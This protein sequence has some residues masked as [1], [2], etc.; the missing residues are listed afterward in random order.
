MS[1]KEKAKFVKEAAMSKKEKAKFVV[2]RCYGA[3]VHVGTLV[4]QDAKLVV[5]Q[6]ARR[7]WRWQGANTLNEV[8]LRGVAQE[9]TRLSEPVSEVTLSDVIEVLA[10]TADAE[11]NLSVSRWAK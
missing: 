10:T 9:Y 8:A 5:L 11:A 6:N 1:K 4:R 7:L 2:V 3:G